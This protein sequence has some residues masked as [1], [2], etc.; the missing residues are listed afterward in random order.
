MASVLEKLSVTVHPQRQL[1]VIHVALAMPLASSSP[2]LCSHRCNLWAFLIWSR[3]PGDEEW[4]MHCGSRKINASSF[5]SLILMWHKQTWIDF[6]FDLH[7]FQIALLCPQCSCTYN[8]T[9]SGDLLGP[10]CT[11]FP[12]VTTHIFLAI[13]HWSAPENSS[14]ISWWSLARKSSNSPQ[15][16]PGSFHFWPWPDGMSSCLRSGPSYSS[17]ESA[18]WRSSTRI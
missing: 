4:V 11:A 6:P 5:P 2:S 17:A 16:G 13:H 8:M 3:I 12:Q 7:T 1:Q 15:P 10:Y 14:N 9:Y 18:R